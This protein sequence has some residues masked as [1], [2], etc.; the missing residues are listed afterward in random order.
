MIIVDGCKSEK[1]ISNF[2]NLEEVLLNVMQEEKMEDRVVTDVLVNDEH[3]SEI[4]PHQAEDL[5]S[6]DI[7]SIEIRTVPA[8]Q[9]ALDISGEMHKVAQLMLSG[10]RN[11]A[12]L[13]REASDGDALELLQDL[14]DVTRD[15]LNMVSDLRTRYLNGANA[16][17]AEKTQNL[18]DLISEMSDV[19]ANEDWVLMA[20]LLEYELAPQC[21]DWA[22]VSDHL[23]KE[24]MERFAQ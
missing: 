24:L 22:V 10:S 7:K 3:F 13:F 16:E 20:D 8:S 19:L 12:R 21:E 23:H 18:S 2:A 11:V 9:M 5:S 6:S 1:V 17:F 4:Y 15:F 14:L